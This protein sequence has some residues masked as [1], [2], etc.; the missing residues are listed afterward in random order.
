MANIIPKQFH[1]SNHNKIDEKPKGELN[2]DL[3]YQ[4]KFYQLHQFP[5]QHIWQF[6]LMNA[7]ITSHDWTRWAGI[8]GDNGVEI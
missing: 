8:F 4:F 1:L 5:C 2:D 6:H 7:V 3:L